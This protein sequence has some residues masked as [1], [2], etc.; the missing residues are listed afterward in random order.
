[1]SYVDENRD[2]LTRLGWSSDPLLLWEKDFGLLWE[3]DF[4]QKLKPGQLCDRRGNR[5]AVTKEMPTGE[6]LS[7]IL[8]LHITALDL[9][10]ILLQT[11]NF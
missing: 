2:I 4:G 11:N 10:H 6:S 7:F 1:M 9:N 5:V 3:K 8:W